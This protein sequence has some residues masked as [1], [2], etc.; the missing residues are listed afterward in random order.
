MSIAV[1]SGFI[2]YLLYSVRAGVGVCFRGSEIVNRAPGPGCE[3][4]ASVMIVD[5]AIHD[6][7]SKPETLVRFPGGKKRFIDI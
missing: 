6:G 4:T 7:Q 1:S 5:N 2:P 3:S